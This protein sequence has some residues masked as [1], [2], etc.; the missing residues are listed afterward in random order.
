MDRRSALKA[1]GASA[2]WPV[3]ARAQ[4]RGRVPVVG[5][6]VT[7]PP[8]DDLVVD[9]LREGLRGFDYVDRTNYRLEVRSARGHLERVPAL[10]EELIQEVDVLV[11]VN[12]IAL[13]AAQKATS[14]VPIVMIGF[15]DDPVELGIIESYRNPGGN[16]TGVFNVNSELSGKRLEILKDALPDLAHVAV[17]WDAFGARQLGEMKAAADM[18]RIRLELIE[19]EDGDDLERAFVRARQAGARA[20]QMN[21]SPVFWVNRRRIAAIALEM[22]M[23][24]MTDNPILAQS[25]CLLA[26][27]ADNANNWARGGYFVD[28]ILNGADAAQLPVERLSRLSLAINLVTAKALEVSIPQSILLRADEVIR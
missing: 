1:L 3:I 17:L 2:L 15:M 22:K 20:V 16:I 26:Y 4:R 8:V 9:K 18:L 6:I 14:T 19:I 5:M 21:F 25:G 28:R 27:G 12:E 24:T 13:R 7:H 23:P 10:I 11:V